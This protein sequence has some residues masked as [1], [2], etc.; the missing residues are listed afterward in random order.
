MAHATTAA[1]RLDFLDGVRGVASLLVVVHHTVEAL[2]REYSIWAHSHVDLGRLG[3][4]A[5]FVVSGYVVGLTLSGQSARTFVVRRFWRLY[6]VYWITTA[7]WLTAWLMLG[8]PMPA[9]LGAFAIAVNLTMVQGV[10]G[11]W[12]I[13]T[14]AWT[15]GIEIAFYS[16]SVAAKLVR[17]LHWVSWAGWLWLA[18]FGV[19]AMSN[20]LAGTSYSALVP[21][22]LFTASL[23]FALFRW[24]VAR[25]RSFWP[26]LAAAV[27]IVPLLGMALGNEPQPGVW[28]PMGFNVS[29]L[30]GLA[31]FAGFYAIRHVALARPLL[32][33]GGISYSLYLIHLTAIQL[34]GHTPLWQI[35]IAGPLAAA[36]L[37]LALAAVLHRWVER[38]STALGRRRSAS[39]VSRRAAPPRDSDARARA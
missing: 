4:V 24:D 37:S 20:L 35:P 21:L 25:D 13:L 34:V 11:G 8:N 36:A 3:I 1:G 32:W 23:G 33:L 9:E 2:S 14:P 26:L 29:Y 39:G 27:F 12:S 18:A 30:A 7:I 15:L 22:L 6:P 5:F 31:L 17:R 10:I 38:P 19:L 28:P 16:Q